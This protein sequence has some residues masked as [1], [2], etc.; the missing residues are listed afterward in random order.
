MSLAI[1]LTISGKSILENE[2]KAAALSDAETW[3]HYSFL[4]SIN[5]MLATPLNCFEVFKEVATGTL[6]W[7]D[8]SAL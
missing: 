1:P 3:N 4:K 2:R 5:F 6:L 8:A 7:R